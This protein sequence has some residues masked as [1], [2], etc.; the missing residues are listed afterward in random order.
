M[1]LAL[2]FSTPAYAEEPQNLKYPDIGILSAKQHDQFLAYAKI[3]YSPLAELLVDRNGDVCKYYVKAVSLGDLQKVAVFEYSDLTMMTISAEK[4][5][6]NNS[7]YFES[8]NY[9]MPYLPPYENVI[10]WFKDENTL[11]EWTT[12]DAYIDAEYS[13]L[14]IEFLDDELTSSDTQLVNAMY[15]YKVRQFNSNK[16]MGTH[17]L[18]RLLEATT[19]LRYNGSEK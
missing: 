3:G 1:L 9:I 4:Q 17:P 15:I 19:G 11:L 2:L 12:T 13:L 7:V 6:D 16:T 8:C 18:L 10:N 14:L 5:Y